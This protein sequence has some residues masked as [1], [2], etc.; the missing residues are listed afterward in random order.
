MGIVIEIALLLVTLALGGLWAYD[1][2]SNYEPFI[3]L[4]SA[5]L[6]VMELVRRQRKKRRKS[7][8]EPLAEV[9][10]L[11]KELKAARDEGRLIPSPKIEPEPTPDSDQ[12]KLQEFYRQKR[13]IE[14]GLIEI[15]NQGKIKV[16]SAPEAV[17]VIAVPEVFRRAMR[18]YLQEGEK[19][20]RESFINLDW[21]L[22]LGETIEGIVE[23]RLS[24]GAWG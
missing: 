12:V 21:A 16:S 13:Q 6:A 8:P 23:K 7:E 17:E 5:I 9:A 10:E 18:E 3:V 1:P 11:L 24:K 19:R 20:I 2:S 14:K 4:C 15:A 22:K